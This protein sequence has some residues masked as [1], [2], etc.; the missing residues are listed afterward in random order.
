MKLSEY[1]KT[2]PEDQTVAIGTIG[3]SGYLYIGSLTDTNFIIAA[4]AT[5]YR[6]AKREL[7]R[8]KEKLNSGRDQTDDYRERMQHRIDI[9]EEYL[10][11]YLPALKRNVLNVYNRFTD[12]SI[13]II[14]D[15]R[16]YGYWDKDEYENKSKESNVRYML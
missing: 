9:R 13:A 7:A 10:S 4:F 16:E 6:N 3:G 5:I 8:D 1:L 11:T 2:L 15:G 14:I 12:D